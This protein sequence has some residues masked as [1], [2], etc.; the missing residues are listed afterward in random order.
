MRE[1]E[2]SYRCTLDNVLHCTVQKC[3]SQWIRQI[4]SDS[5]TFQYCGLLAHQ[6]QCGLPGGFDPRKL[7]ERTFA[8]PFPTATIVTP[9]YIDFA[10]YQ[11]IPKPA[12]YRTFFVMR[13]PRDVVVSWYFSAKYSHVAH[14]DLVGIRHD[15]SR[16]PEVDGMRWVI[17]HL[18]SYGLFQA[19]RSWAD[20]PSKDPNVML[21]RF[22]DLVGGD[23]AAWFDRLFGHLDIRIPSE[24]QREMLQDH[25][26]EMLSGRARGHE[27]AH[28][29]YRKGVA[30]DWQRHFDDRVLAHFSQA[31]GVVLELWKYS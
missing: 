18:K 10:G 3:A 11:S 24:V 25:S 30:G 16:W 8:Q 20:A 5:R 12:S 7:T 26:F 14:G 19:Q 15:L 4:L 9:I 6:Y 21:I 2:V 17:D 31:A 23:Q 27:D 13:D 1:S 22:E 29:H 28:A